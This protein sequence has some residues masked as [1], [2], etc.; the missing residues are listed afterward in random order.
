MS[1]NKGSKALTAKVHA[2]YGRKLTRQ[3]YRELVRKQSVN[4]VAAY[5]KQQTSYGPL[6]REVNE[7]LIHRGQLEN[8]LKRDLFN[9]YMKV[10]HYVSSGEMEFYKFLI[11]R[12]E[13]DEIL[14]CIRLLNANREEEY[15]LSLPSFFAD[16]ASFDLYGLAK[17]KNFD[18][19][20]KLLKPTQYYDILKKYD[21]S[22][23]EKIDIIRIEIEFNKLYYS[24]IFEII[25]RTFSGKVAEQVKNSFGMMIDLSNITSII[26]L[27]KYFDAKR[28]YIEKLL[29]PFYFKVKP[30]ELRAIMEANDANA[31]W[32]AACQTYYGTAFKKY[33]FEYIEKYSHQIMYHYH[34]QLLTFTDSAPVAVVSFLQLEDIEIKNIIHIIE[35]IRYGLAPSEIEKLLVGVE[36]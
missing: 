12:M 21:P 19:L 15:L 5:L 28:D 23:G 10:F 2:M 22:A 31:A 25:D 4:E 32:L 13:I 1:Y 33:D 30:K 9:Q 14:F 18:D 20:L 24:R 35:G 16:H 36:D 6:L 27:K 8:I 7:N 17:V 29:L 3:N 26:R 11:M 34:K